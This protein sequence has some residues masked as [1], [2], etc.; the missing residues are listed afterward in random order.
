MPQGELFIKTKGSITPK[1]GASVGD[2]WI[3]AYLQWGV[4]FSE[5]ALSALMTPAPNKDAVENKSRI[6]N[7]KRVRRDSQYAK[8]D[9]RD[10]SIE[11]HITAKSKSEFFDN[12]SRFCSEVLDAG[13]FDIKSIYCQSLIFRMTY[14]SCSQFS[15]FVQRLAKF[16]LRLNEPD[17]SNRGATDNWEE[18][19]QEQE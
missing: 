12:Y 8:K 4:S 17:P 13:F 2:G 18:Q 19:E 9:E 6:V 7:G 3:D 15:E 5:T 11:M 1:Q 10:V 14:L 16:T